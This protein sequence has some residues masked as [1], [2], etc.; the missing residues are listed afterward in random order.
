MTCSEVYWRRWNIT[1]YL[2]IVWLCVCPWSESSSSY[3][4]SFSSCPWSPC[5]QQ[6]LIFM[7]QTPSRSGRIFGIIFKMHS[8]FKQKWSQESLIDRICWWSFRKTSVNVRIRILRIIFTQVQVCVVFGSDSERLFIFSLVFLCSLF[9]WS[10]FPLFTQSVS[11]LFY[12]AQAA[13]FNMHGSDIQHL[14]WVNVVEQTDS[15]E[16]QHYFIAAS[17]NEMSA[18]LNSHVKEPLLRNCSLVANPCRPFYNWAPE[19]IK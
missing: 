16:G 17:N 19:S 9:P 5:F 4:S 3:L 10:F 6:Q 15:T 12:M 11:H 18:K 14:T 2:V 8:V 13:G 7:V 1:D